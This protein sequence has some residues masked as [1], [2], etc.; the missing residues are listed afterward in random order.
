ME[1]KNCGCLDGNIPIPSSLYPNSVR[2]WCVGVRSRL[3]LCLGV[4]IQSGYTVE[5]TMGGIYARCCFCIPRDDTCANCLMYFSQQFVATGLCALICCSCALLLIINL[6]C[7][8]L[9]YLLSG[10]W[11]DRS[12]PV[13]LWSVCD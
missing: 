10:R 8:I 3:I 11:F 5:V 4:R 6:L 13:T 1:A 2:D 12:C 7:S 9:I